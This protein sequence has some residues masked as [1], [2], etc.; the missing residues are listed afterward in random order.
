MLIVCENAKIS[1]VFSCPV[2]P[3]ALIGSLPAARKSNKAMGDTKVTELL[4]VMA[5]VHYLKHAELFA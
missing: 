4:L 1:E 5:N 2:G 3:A